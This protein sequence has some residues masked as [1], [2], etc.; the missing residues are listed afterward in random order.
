MRLRQIALSLLAL[1]SLSAPA[2]PIDS[3]YR[4]L[5]AALARRDHYARCKEQ[6]IDSLRRL[7]NV[8]PGDAERLR[9]TDDLYR[10][11]YTY[12]FDSAMHYARLQQQVADRMGHPVGQALS[13]IHQSV[14]LSTSGYFSESVAQ[15]KALRLPAA[16][17]ADS[18]L[19]AAYYYACEWAY[20]TWAEYSADSVYAPVYYRHEMAYHDSLVSVLPDGSQQWHYWQAERA[21]RLRQYAEAET[22]YLQA[23]RSLRQDERLYAMTTYGLALVYTR[24]GRR[25]LYEEYLLRAAISDQ[26]CPLKENLALQELA[27][28][29][30][31]EYPARLGKANDYLQVAMQDARF[32]NNRLRLL[33]VADKFSD[34]ARSYQAWGEREHRRMMWALAVVTLL[35]LGLTVSLA[36]LWRQLR[37]NRRQHEALAGMNTHLQQLNEALSQ[38]NV[39]RERYVALFLDLCA[40]YI[41]KLNNFQQLVKRKVM[42]KQADDLLKMVNATRLSEVDA[43]E[44]FVNFDT[45]FLNLYPD[46]V[47]SFNALLR[48]DA[49]IRLERGDILNTELRIY[50]LVRIGVKDSAKIAT[51]LFYSTQTIYNYRSAVKAR[52][53]D[54][55][56]FEQDVMELCRV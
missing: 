9:L 17:R 11:T 24:T 5:D 30:Y 48:P 32:Y 1:I 28:L 12:S 44:F 6:R 4:A 56:R 7:L 18:T 50:A 25:D 47:R 22:H 2:A 15:L 19:L 20:S 54:K 36:F 46:F 37:R 29:I 14:L 43:K 27:Q 40:A 16:V 26:V 21:Y 55:D 39:T 42:A 52:A 33:E 41:S 8:A 45:A 23:L 49:Q 34:I 10:E 31:K 35:A 13:R 53:K 3:L 51:L 38:T